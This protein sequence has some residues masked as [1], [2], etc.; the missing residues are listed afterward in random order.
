M[1]ITALLRHTGASAGASEE[2]ALQTGACWAPGQS[3]HLHTPLAPSGPCRVNESHRL[4][5]AAPAGRYWSWIQVWFTSA[6]F[7]H[8]LPQP[9]VSHDSH[10]A[11]SLLWA[12]GRA[13]AS[14][15]GTTTNHSG[16]IRT[17]LS[18]TGLSHVESIHTC[19][20]APGMWASSQRQKCH[21]WSPS[22]EGPVTPA[23]VTLAHSHVLGRLQQMSSEVPPNLSRS[24]VRCGGFG[25]AALLPW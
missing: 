21:L 23:R 17:P 16:H 4:W 22:R 11:S 12:Q 2:P 1:H 3:C 6:D 19:W 13:A 8:L 25:C 20:R 5:P 18:A 9:V 15:Q 7:W 14:A 24:R 10:R